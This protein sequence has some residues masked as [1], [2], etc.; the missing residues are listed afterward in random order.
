MPDTAETVCV[1]LRGL[2]RQAENGTAL[3][4]QEGGRAM[5]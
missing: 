2:S 5:W 4:S 3:V 1:I